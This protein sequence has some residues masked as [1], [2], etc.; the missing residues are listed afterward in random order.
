[1]ILLFK[2]LAGD[3]VHENRSFCCYNIDQ[4]GKSPPKMAPVAIVPE[5]VNYAQP[6]KDNLNLPG[7]TRARLEKAGIDLSEGYP[8]RRRTCSRCNLN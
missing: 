3:L 7:P 6:R 8:V 2:F 5:I 1:M 4:V